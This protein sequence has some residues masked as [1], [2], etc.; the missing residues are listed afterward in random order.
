M[1]DESTN[2]ATSPPGTPRGLITWICSTVSL[3]LVRSGEGIGSRE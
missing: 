3:N 2:A 1:T